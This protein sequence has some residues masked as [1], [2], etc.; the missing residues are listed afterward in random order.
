M[1]WLRFGRFPRLAVGSRYDIIK[2]SIL[3]FPIAFTLV[4]AYFLIWLRNAT[5]RRDN[6]I[7]RVI[8]QKMAERRIDPWELA[9]IMGVAPSFVHG[10]LENKQRIDAVAA[11]GLII[12]FPQTDL[13][14][15]YNLDTLQ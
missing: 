7:R 2:M 13:D 3:L 14:Y 5:F 15:W 11:G 8:Y 9:R 1:R 4:L 10:L 6:R 12:A